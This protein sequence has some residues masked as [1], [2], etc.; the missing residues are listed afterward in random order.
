MP[1]RRAEDQDATTVARRP[2]APPTIGDVIAGKYR[3]E[4]ELGHGA[5]GRVFEA[6]HLVLRHVVALKFM[7]PHLLRVPLAVKRFA[8]EARAAARLRSD[9]AVRVLDV[10]HHRGAPFIVM[11][12][13]TG[14]SLARILREEGPLPVREA[15]ELVVQACD[16]LD[17]A[18]AAGIIHR[19]VKPENL[20]VETDARSG[21]RRLKVL[22]FGLAKA[23][24]PDDDGFLTLYGPASTRRAVGSPQYMSPEQVRE[25]KDVDLRTDVWSLGVTL[26]ELLTGVAPFARSS[27]TR[28][29]AAILHGRE[30][31]IR[32]LRPD[33]PEPL[34]EVLLR[35]LAKERDGRFP[36]AKALS[37]ALV[38]AIE[39]RLDRAEAVIDDEVTPVAAPA[40]PVLDL[41]IDDAV[42][43]RLRRG[44]V[45]TARIPRVQP[46]PPA[47][48]AF[49][50]AILLAVIV[51]SLALGV[52]GLRLHAAIVSVAPARST[53]GAP[54]PPPTRP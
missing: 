45:P 25:A 51:S 27:V 22:D 50:P 39:D 21:R 53:L 35:C 23:K 1:A 15:V 5:M 2:I 20:F 47:P 19:D 4:A 52:L 32:A 33:V 17:E 40:A 16:A 26:Y 30:T 34:A 38:G 10:D 42:T 3:I 43:A 29:L 12:R 36:S 6:N 8:R 48:K 44:D 7:H 46:R 28:V 31:P 49:V 9:H 11:E 13:L 37:K 24:L 18:H 14:M 41:R 54:A